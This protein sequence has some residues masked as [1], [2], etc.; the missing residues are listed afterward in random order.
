ML[1]LRARSTLGPGCCPAAPAAAASSAA[2]RCP[3]PLT[4][5]CR[6]SSGRTRRLS[7]SRGLCCKHA[8]PH[9]IMHH[10]GGLLQTALPCMTCVKQNCGGAAA[11]LGGGWHA[12]DRPGAFMEAAAGRGCWALVAACRT[13]WSLMPLQG[14]GAEARNVVQWAP[15]VP[16]SSLLG[17]GWL[18]TCLP[19]QIEHCAS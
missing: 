14:R 9:A 4:A 8:Q 1:T 19:T 5:Q 17:P 6:H 11:C 3:A 16:A 7:R 10:G 15:R 13:P 18:Q 12:D 2:V